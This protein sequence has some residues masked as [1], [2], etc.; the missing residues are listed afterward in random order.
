MKLCG[1][2]YFY[3][4]S[5]TIC[6]ETLESY[7]KMRNLVF[8]KLI[9]TGRNQELL[10]FVP[11]RQ[12]LDLSLV[13]YFFEEHDPEKDEIYITNYMMRKWGI[14][15]ATLCEDAMRNTRNIMGE[16][17]RPMQDVI[18]ELLENLH[19]VYTNPEP[20]EMPMYILSNL[21]KRN[22]AVCMLNEDALR[23]MAD[24]LESDL[25]VLPSS[26]HEVILVP[27]GGV[28]PGELNHVIREVNQ[29]EL[30]AA[31]IL[32]DHAYLFSRQMGRLFM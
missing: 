21:W 17:I 18:A 20:N 32:S 25:Y 14:D 10:S 7:D 16:C 31:D 24:M 11:S 4:E 6:P 19:A 28:S 1:T 8:A 22:G 26:V 12:I 13:F 5:D 15:V 3:A 2:T 9:N 23:E 30:N 29:S 27:A